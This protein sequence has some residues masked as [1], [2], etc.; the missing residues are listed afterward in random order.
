MDRINDSIR[1]EEGKPKTIVI[2][3]VQLRSEEY[4]EDLSL[5]DREPA[6]I[7]TDI[8]SSHRTLVAGYA[9]DSEEDGKAG[10][11]GVH[12]IDNPV[13]KLTDDNNIKVYDGNSCKYIISYN[14]GLEIA[15]PGTDSNKTVF[16]MSSEGK[17]TQMLI[18]DDSMIYNSDNID[19]YV[20][21]QLLFIEDVSA[22]TSG[23]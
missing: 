18:D 11:I 12:Y 14:G 22:T 10:G 16:K 7:D 19:D 15:L 3:S 1:F 20:D 2:D 13:F 9:D 23:S 8:S 17:I 5:K 4:N 21:G 6:L